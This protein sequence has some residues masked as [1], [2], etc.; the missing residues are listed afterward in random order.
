VPAAVSTIDFGD[1]SDIAQSV[2]VDS[3]GRVILGGYMFHQDTGEYDFAIA[4]LNINGGVDTSFSGDGKATIDFGSYYDIGQSVAVD[5]SGR[6]LISGYS[7][8]NA[9]TGYDFAVARLTSG[10]SLDLTFGDAGRTTIDFGSDSD[11]GY[12]V[13]VDGSGRIVVGGYS[14]Q[15]AT[16]Y[17]FAVARLEGGGE[18]LTPQQLIGL[19]NSRID[20]LVAD[21]R[22]NSGQ[23]ISLKAKL[24]DIVEKIDANL[25]NAAAGKLGAFINQVEAWDGT[26][27]THEEAQVLIELAQLILDQQP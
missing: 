18:A 23:A 3:S 14:Y 15:G 26:I 13:A 22:L 8:Q 4:R 9:T 12:S 20:Q 27:L 11:L 24:K 17:D 5:N 7:Y 2:A 21:G 19:L 10:G 1:S 25:W 6:V 16:N